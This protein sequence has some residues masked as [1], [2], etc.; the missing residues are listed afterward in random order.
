MEKWDLL[1]PG[2]GEEVIKENDQESEFSPLS[3]QWY[4][5]R[6]SVNVTTYSQSNNKKIKKNSILFSSFIFV[7][8]SLDNTFQTIYSLLMYRR[9]NPHHCL[10]CSCFPLSLPVDRDISCP[11][12]KIQLK[13]IKE[14]SQATPSTLH[15]ET[16]LLRNITAGTVL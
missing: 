15:L 16:F 9:H 7:I 6:T 5:V 14:T 11:N 2:M 1:I 4:I 10:R 3:I 12:F 13:T 8:T